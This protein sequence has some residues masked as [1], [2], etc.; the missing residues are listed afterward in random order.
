VGGLRKTIPTLE[1]VKT[2]PATVDLVQG[3]KPYNISRNHA[4]QLAK[5]GEFPVRVLRIGRFYRVIT[6]EIIA[7]LEGSLS[8]PTA[9]AAAS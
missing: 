4:Y 8:S 6:A 5:A 1:E 2:W 3:A 7:D 9:E